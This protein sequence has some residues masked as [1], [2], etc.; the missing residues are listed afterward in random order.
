[1]H[2]NTKNFLKSNHNYIFKHTFNNLL[3][4][5]TYLVLSE[6]FY[7]SFSLWSFSQSPKSSLCT[8]TNSPNFYHGLSMINLF[9]M[10]SY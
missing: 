2:F 10:V 4:F 8:S 9:I 7:F 3:K 1:M 5:Q 6:I